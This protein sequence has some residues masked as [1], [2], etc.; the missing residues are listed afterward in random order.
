MIC[1]FTGTRPALLPCA[2]KLSGLYLPLIEAFCHCTSSKAADRP[3]AAQLVQLFT[4]IALENENSQHES[5]ILLS[6]L[7]SSFVDLDTSADTS[8]VADSSSLASSLGVSA[9]DMSPEVDSKA[10][11]AAADKKVSVSPL[12]PH[13]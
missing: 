6:D 9:V 12:R 3:S 8:L 10:P 11:T 2:A 1:S 13:N 7:S 4:D 5:T